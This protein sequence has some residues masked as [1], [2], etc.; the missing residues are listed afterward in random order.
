MSDDLAKGYMIGYLLDD[1]CL[2]D[3]NRLLSA[4][5][6]K[7]VKSPVIMKHLHLLR[8]CSYGFSPPTWPSD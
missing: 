6:N 3:V 4:R 5:R 7:V 2:L 8:C 1:I